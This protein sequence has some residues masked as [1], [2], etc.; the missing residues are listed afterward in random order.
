MAQV[1]NLTDFFSLQSSKPKA[2]RTAKP[3]MTLQQKTVKQLQAELEKFKS[4]A[5][6]E[7]PAQER[8][9]WIKEV[10]GEVRV[11]AKAGNTKLDFGGSNTLHTDRKRL[12]KGIKTLIQHIESGS[13]DTQYADVEKALAARG[14]K[15]SAS[16]KS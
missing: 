10:D 12:D 11:V 14:A 5:K 15:L 6:Y 13:F 1:A 9:A 7:K 2:T 3:K 8:A 4:G 16:K